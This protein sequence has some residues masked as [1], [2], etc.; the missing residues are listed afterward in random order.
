[1]TEI[2]A[3]IVQLWFL[4]QTEFWNNPADTLCYLYK[5]SSNIFTSSRTPLSTTVLFLLYFLNSYSFVFSS[6]LFSFWREPN[7]FSWCS[8]DYFMT[9]KLAC[10]SESFSP[11]RFWHHVVLQPKQ[12]IS[13]LGRD[14]L[15]HPCTH[16]QTE[17]R[18]FRL[19]FFPTYLYR[20]SESVIRISTE[21]LDSCDRCANLACT[22]RS[23]SDESVLLAK[24][25]VISSCTALAVLAPLGP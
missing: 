22:N 12:E 25:C 15:D 20:H 17:K 19:L 6:I 9:S 4:L 8:N 18:V 1:M 7:L 13:S 14:I 21:A 24:D 16:F 11:K 5:T 3:D 2:L 23:E 10:C